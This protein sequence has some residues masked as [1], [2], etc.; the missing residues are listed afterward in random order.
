MNNSLSSIYKKYQSTF[1]ISFLIILSFLVFENCLH[2]YFLEVDDFSTLLHSKRRIERIFITNTMGENSGGDYRPLEVLSHQFDRTVYGEDSVLGRHITNLLLHIF[3]VILVYL[4]TISLTKNKSIGLI[5]GLLFAVIIMNGSHLTPVAWISGR[6]DLIVTF[7]YLLSIIFF[8]NFLNKD[9]IIFYIISLFSFGLAILSKEMAFTLPIIILLYWILFCY[10][11]KD[12]ILFS[13]KRIHNFLKIYILV[14]IFLVLL[15]LLVNPNIFAKFL[16]PDKNLQQITINK[17]QSIQI[18]ILLG[19]GIIGALSTLTFIMLKLNLSNKVFSYLTSIIYIFPYFIIMFLYFVLRFTFLGGVGGNYQS[20]EG[21]MIFHMGMDTFARDLFGLAG[22]VWPLKVSYNIFIFNIQIEHSVIFY[23][24]FIVILASLIS[25]LILLFI[26]KL[27]LL[28]WSYLWVFITLIPVH[29]ILVNSVNYRPRY[30]YLPAV[31]FCIFISVLIHQFMKRKNIF[32]NISNRILGI[33]FILFIIVFN[34][35]FIIKNNNSLGVSGKMAEDF[36]KDMKKS[37]NEISKNTHLFFVDFP[38]STISSM[39]KIYSYA[40]MY[41]LLNFIFGTEEHKQNYLFSICLFVDDQ[42]E[43]NI[44]IDWQ[45]KNSFIIH[46]VDINKFF[47]LPEELSEK[48]RKFKK[49]YGNKSPRLQCFSFKNEIKESKEAI[50]KV[51]TL[52]KRLNNSTVQV[53]LKEPTKNAFFFLY[54]NSHFFL[55]KRN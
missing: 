42:K 52:D 12:T 35:F 3:N 40:G 47:V 16:S 34:S 2:N 45:N 20:S 18:I 6:I 22:L 50:Y 23:T 14:G 41:E 46:N 7:F 48:D 32:S 44:K 37:K 1:N 13:T 49:I 17:I 29:N 28:T 27:K 43:N 15:G 24:L 39:D 31:G 21:N 26:N 30:L 19:G 33:F 53:I 25:V 38:I 9:S 4:L 36:V 51:L 8:T 5:S 55:I 54:K 10:Y 11:K